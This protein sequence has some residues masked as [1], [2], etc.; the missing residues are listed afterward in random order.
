MDNALFVVTSSMTNATAVLDGFTITSAYSSGMYNQYS[1]VTIKNCT[2]TNNVTSNALYWFGAA[3]CNSNSSPTA[4]NCNFLFNS[5]KY[6]GGGMYNGASNPILIN[7]VFIGNSAQYYG[8][9]MSNDASSPLLVNCIFIENVSGSNGGGIFNIL[10]NPM[11]TNC[12]LTNNWAGSFGG[13]IYNKRSEANLINCILWGNT[14]PE[15]QGQAAQ[16]YGSYHPVINYCCIEGWTGDLGGSGNIGTD[17]C[18]VEQGCWDVNGVWIEGDYHLLLGS[19]CIDAGDPDYIL[20]PDETD[21]DGNPRVIGGRI[22]MGAYEYFSPRPFAEA[23]PDQVVECACN[24][25]EGTKVTLD[26]TGSYDEGDNP[27]TFTW[28][29]PFVESPANGATPTVTLESGC[30]GEYVITLV[31]NNGIEDSEPNDV[32]ITVVDTT[33]PEFALTVTPSVLWPPNHK[34]VEITPSWTVSDECDASPDVSLVN[35]VMSEGDD[36]IGVG[37]TSDD[38]QIGEDGSIY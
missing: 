19:P 4:T 32:V 30:P 33:P 37:H 34:M 14:N 9:G 22:D 31:V 3:M 5:G 25:Q 20:E 18:F 24:T 12:T 16:I 27:L 36:T 10:S 15:E 23:G 7:C 26:G 29:G 35:I 28:T 13:G 17:P 38:I 11:L 8:G 6:E 1:S 2:F 21:L